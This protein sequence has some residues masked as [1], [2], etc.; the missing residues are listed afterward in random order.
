MLL[1]QCDVATL[2]DASLAGLCGRLGP[3]ARAVPRRSDDCSTRRS[4][5]PDWTSLRVVELHVPKDMVNLLPECVCNE[6]G[7]LDGKAVL[8]IL[9][10]HAVDGTGRASYDFRK[11]CLRHAE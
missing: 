7:T 9:G 6:A 4:A 8:S 11:L 1:R 2:R 5:S 3:T 10:F